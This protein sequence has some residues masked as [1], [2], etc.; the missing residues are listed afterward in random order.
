MTVPLYVLT[1]AMAAGKSTIARAL[2]QRFE[3]SAHVSGDPFLRMI[4]KGGAVMGPV[5][6][7]EAIMQ[8][9]LRQ[10]I[11]IDAVRRF[12]AAGFATVYEDILIGADFVRVTAALV[13]ISPRVV[14]LNPSVETLAER[15]AQ[16]HK[17]G[18]GEH[19]PPNVLA[20]A[21]RSETPRRGLW[22]DTS[23]MSVDEV[24]EEILVAW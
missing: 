3:R 14:V 18:Y 4:A 6:D 12:V 15:D 9:H 1:G 21:L 24:V 22:L 23:S 13:D 17:T 8:L 7:R 16:R 11:A 19:F 5:L 2:V 10:D 20:H